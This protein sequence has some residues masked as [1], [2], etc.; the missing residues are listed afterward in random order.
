MMWYSFWSMT[1]P[2]L[3]FSR[4]LWILKDDDIDV[5]ERFQ[6][7]SG[8]RVQRFH[9]RSPNETSYAGLGWI[10]LEYYIYIKKLLFIR[11]IA[12]LNDNS[13]YKTI[14]RLW[15]AKYEEDLVLS[16]QNN[17]D[18]PIFDMIKVAEHFGLLNDIRGMIPG[19]SVNRNGNE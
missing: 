16:R 15:L 10:R 8:C 11:S 6:H 7:Y 14:F 2:I 4:E 13:I 17:H 18:S 5:I 9:S 3:S 19:F 1:V 12:I